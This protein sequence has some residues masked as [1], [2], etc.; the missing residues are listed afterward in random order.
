M[1]W[2]LSSNMTLFYKVFIPTMWIVFFGLFTLSLFLTATEEFTAISN[3]S[4]RIPV[5]IGYLVC[6]AFLFFTV[7]DLK[8]VDI[9]T[10]HIMVS[11]YFKTYRYEIEDIEKI[12]DIN[13]II[14]TLWSIHLKSKGSLGRKIRLI[15]DKGNLKEFIAENPQIF[16]HML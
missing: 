13:L 8:R 16:E 7:M 5:L 4:F 1:T 14:M 2:R 11:N 9:T 10:T 3:N 15:L 12:K 6:L